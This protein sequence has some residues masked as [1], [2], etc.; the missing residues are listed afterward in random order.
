MADA[1]KTLVAFESG[2]MIKTITF[3]ERLNPGKIYLNSPRLFLKKTL[4]SIRNEKELENRSLYLRSYPVF[5]NVDAT[6]I[7]QLKCPLCPNGAGYEGRSR[8]KMSLENYKKLMD[9]VGDYL[10]RIYLF[11]WGEPLLNDDVFEMVAYARGKLIQTVF[12]TNLNHLPSAEKLVASGLDSLKISIDGATPG[13]YEKYRRGGNLDTVLK[14]LKLISDEKKR[15]NSRLPYMTWQFLVFKY[16]IDEMEAA[17]KLAKETGCDAI[18]FIGGHSLMGLMPFSK[19][20]ELVAKGKDYLMERDSEWSIYNEKDELK[21]PASVC[22]WLWNQAAINWNGSVSP[23]SGVFPEKYDFGNCFESTLRDVWNND[24]FHR[25]R[26]A[27][28]KA[29]LGDYKAPEGSSN[30]CE[31]CA[32][33]HNYVDGVGLSRMPAVF[34]SEA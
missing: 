21:N 17:T 5:L 7:C 11:N 30:V 34:L 19:V 20:S 32:R 28:R 13:T 29:E 6:S 12:S 1:V 2:L 16:N 3:R 31:L 22:K 27:V 8:G 26:E 10:I 14:N 25:A 18:Q 9:E 23:C 15:R 24:A 4:N 33:T